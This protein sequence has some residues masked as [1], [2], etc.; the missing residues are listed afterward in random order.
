MLV[1]GGTWSGLVSAQ[2]T[3]AS[4]KPAAQQRQSQE[5]DLEALA[6]EL[7][8]AESSDSAAAGAAMDSYES[9]SA[10]PGARGT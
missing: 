5:E 4:E 1:V 9:R 7:E 3:K 8:A 6:K 2:E 10:S